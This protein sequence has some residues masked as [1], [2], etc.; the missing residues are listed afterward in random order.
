V[1]VALV[2]APEKVEG[3]CAIGDR[4]SKIKDEVCHALHLAIIFDDVEIILH[5]GPEGDIEV[6]GIS[7]MVAKEQLLNGNPALVGSATVARW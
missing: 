4:L 7:L 5:E 6:E 3:E 1:I 2:E